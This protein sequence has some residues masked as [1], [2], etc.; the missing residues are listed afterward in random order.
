MRW[1]RSAAEHGASVVDFVLVTVVLL[2]LVLGILQVALVLH[3]RNTLTAAASDGARL[4]ATVDRGPADGVR[5]T[6][7][8]IS[9]ALSARFARDVTA[10]RSVVDGQPGVEVR[11]V[12]VVP[13]LGLWGPATRLELT[14][15]AIEEPS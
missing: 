8:Q 2:P 9:G 10:R 7:E 4:A 15:H 13:P 5:R 12:A 14:G 1:R 11:V 6:R 3:V